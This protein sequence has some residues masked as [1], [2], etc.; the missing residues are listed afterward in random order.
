MTG[1]GDQ[2]SPVSGLPE[3]VCV[4]VNPMRPVP[5]DKTA[6]VFQLLN[7]KPLSL[8]NAPKVL[9]QFQDRESLLATIRAIGNDLLAPAK[10]VVP[11]IEEVL[12][13]LTTQAGC[14]L[15]Q[16]SGGGPTCFG[17]FKNMSTAQEACC[18]LIA[19][20]PTWWV[21]SSHLR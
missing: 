14:E 16:L 10:I 8:A 9:P 18:Q 5:H 15:A 7:A 1:V 3:L 6:Q 2:I 4:L 19:D 17:I 11:Q 12:A 20:H 13:V 21:M